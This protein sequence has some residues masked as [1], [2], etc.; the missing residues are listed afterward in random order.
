MVWRLAMYKLR[1]ALRVLFLVILSQTRVMASR[2]V[3]T[4][5]HDTTELSE[6]MLYR[7]SG[8]VISMSKVYGGSNVDLCKL[9]DADK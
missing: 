4:D 2:V 5:I 7:R 8:C 3:Y 9:S 6:K 1:K